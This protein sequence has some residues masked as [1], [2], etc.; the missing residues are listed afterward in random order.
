MTSILVASSALE[1]GLVVAAGI[2]FLAMIVAVVAVIVWSLAGVFSAA[3]HPPA[4]P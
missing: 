3:T 1:V 4:S 2:I